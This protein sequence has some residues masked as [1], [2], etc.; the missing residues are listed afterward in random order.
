MLLYKGYC[1][2]AD[3]NVLL[4]DTNECG[5]NPCMNDATCHDEVNAYNCTCVEGYTGYNCE[6][7]VYFSDPIVQN[8]CSVS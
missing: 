6:T 3:I 8:A 7:G 1:R 2:N 5:S 4:T